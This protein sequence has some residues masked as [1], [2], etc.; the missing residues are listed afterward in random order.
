MFESYK[1]AHEYFY[2]KKNHYWDLGL[3]NIKSFLCFFG[4]PEN[5][6][7]IIQIAGTNGK[8]STSAFLSNILI[9]SGYKVG[10]Y[11]SPVVFE[12]RE[13]IT[14]NN[15]IMS[16]ED[17]T[18]QV[19]EMKEFIEE[20][21]RK[22]KLPTIFE[23][24][25]AMAINYFY[26]NKCDIVILEAGLGG[27]TD[28]TNVSDRNI[29][30]IITSVSMDHMKYLGDTIEKIAEIKSG[31]IKKNSIVIVGDNIESV[32]NIMKAK[33]QLTN[34]VNIVI[35]KLN[36]KDV[37]QNI[38][39]QSFNYISSNKTVFNNIRLMMLGVF[40]S[41][42]ASIAIEAAC[43]LRKKGYNISDNSIKIGL[44]KAVCKGRFEIISYNPLVILDGA[45]N[46]DAANRLKE[47]INV[48]LNDYNIVFIMGIFADK[49]YKSIINILNPFMKKIVTVTALDKRA[50]SGKEIKKAINTE[51]C[52]S[53]IEIKEAQNFKDALMYA[54]E[55]AEESTK[56]N[57]KKT[58]IIAFGSLSYLKYIRRENTRDDNWK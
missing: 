50:L 5:K 18:N 25:T 12:E 19:N 14:I 9:E 35:N 10:R 27:L 33:A 53:I 11:N 31:I 26:K 38:Y 16:E 56:E 20:S 43:A 44:K 23:L 51:L 13:N 40:Q 2:E 41:E 29:M 57:N 7:N 3:E 17:F 24:E 30:S 48:Y 55:M 45:H 46:P 54:K 32:K 52:E 21:E 1:E 22:G 4:S 8:G 37:F 39:E 49:D 47:N 15:K 36:I 42:N 28:A 6:L 34:S 58:A